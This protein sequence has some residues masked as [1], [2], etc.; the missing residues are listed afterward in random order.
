MRRAVLVAAAVT[1]AWHGVL[2]AAAERLPPLGTDAWPDTGATVVNLLAAL[3]PVAVLVRYGWWRASWLRRPR[4][5][6][7]ALLVPAVVFS[8]LPLAQGLEGTTTALLSSALLFLCLGFSEELLSR[9]VVQ[10]LLGGL[11]PVARVLV[12]GLLFGLGH[13]LSAMWFGRPVGDSVFQ[14]ISAATFGVGY[15]ALRLRTDAIWPLML[16]HGLGDWTQ[17]NS[18]GAVPWPLQLLEA[19]LWVG[20]GVA[21]ARGGDASQQHSRVAA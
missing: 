15:A 12:V 17:I 14:V 21:L 7:A 6:Q 5:L 11:A 16:L 9:G 4:P 3:V 2:F 18:P 13:V 20:Y 8:L 10:E 19:V 1:V